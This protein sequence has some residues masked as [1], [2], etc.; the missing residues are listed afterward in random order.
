MNLWYIAVPFLTAIMFTIGSYAYKIEGTKVKKM[1]A[2]FV[3]FWAILFSA[4]ISTMIVAESNRGIVQL[5]DG[6][7]L[8][9]ESPVLSLFAFAVTIVVIAFFAYY[10]FC[11]VAN[12]AARRK[13][14]RLMSTTR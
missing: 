14:K 12:V 13:Y 11:F 8:P 6:L 10:F 1:K 3:K 2:G 4:I 7:L 9:G 5:F